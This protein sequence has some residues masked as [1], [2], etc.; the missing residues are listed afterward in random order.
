MAS[1]IKSQALFERIPSA[2][3]NRREA[4][5]HRHGPGN[6]ASES[7]DQVL[8]PMH[9][10]APKRKKRRSSRHH[11]ATHTRISALQHP[12]YV[13]CDRVS[14]SRI[15]ETRSGNVSEH[16]AA[17]LETSAMNGVEEHGSA[18]QAGRPPLSALELRERSSMHAAKQRR[19][20][21]SPHPRQRVI[22]DHATK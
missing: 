18:A 3:A 19:G 6:F 15:G 21:A 16:S 9:R 22:S 20:G 8:E 10:A 14:H 1:L 13:T 11:T 12:T 5:N 17:S 7:R 4:A 2:R